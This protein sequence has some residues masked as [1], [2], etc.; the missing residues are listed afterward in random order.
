LSGVWGFSACAIVAVKNE[1][2][3]IGELLR[4]LESLDYPADRLEFR[5]IDDGSSDRAGEIVAAWI[6]RN[7]SAHMLTLTSSVGSR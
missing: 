3:H 1:E 6:D 5:I 7:A 4:H 2:R